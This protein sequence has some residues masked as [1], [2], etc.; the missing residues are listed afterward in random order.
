MARAKIKIMISSR[1]SDQFPLGNDQAQ[2]LSQIRK[3]LKKLLEAEEILGRKIFEVWINE[4]APPE[5]GNKD[6]LATCLEAVKNADILLVLYN[7]NAGWSVDQTG[8]GICHDELMTGFSDAPGKVTAVSIFNPKHEDSPSSEND[9]KFQTYV[10]AL[11][12]FRGGEIKDIDGLKDRVKEAIREMALKL[13]HDG[14][15][16]ARKSAGDSGPALDW[17]R[18]NF[19]DRHQVMVNAVSSSLTGLKGAEKIE[20][21][22]VTPINGTKVL[23]IPNA[24]PSAYTVSAAREMVGQPFLKDHQKVEELRKTKAGPVHLIACQKTITEAQAMKLLGFP[25]ATIVQSAFGVYVSDNIQKIQLCL[26]A[27]CKDES[28]TRHNVQRFLEW[29]NKTGEA[30]LLVSR[31]KSRYKIVKTIEEEAR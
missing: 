30:E 11:N 19:S 27:N 13:M 12:L 5:P 22:V 31:A 10:D 2:P 3:D 17:T 8:N 26:I 16:E 6:S 1:C 20:A 21:G 24:I 23:F 15:K 4:D 25:D 7:G 28:S 29:L 9:K 18:M 14:S